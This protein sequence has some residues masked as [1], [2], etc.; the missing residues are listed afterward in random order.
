MSVVFHDLAGGLEVSSTRAQRLAL[1]G[2]TVTPAPVSSVTMQ[3]TDSFTNRSRVHATDRPLV[4]VHVPHWQH[5]GL[6][7]DLLSLPLLTLDPSCAL[8]WTSFGLLQQSAACCTRFPFDNHLKL[9]K[10]P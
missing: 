3:L 2:N 7:L 1:G 6:D 8:G 5:D 4:R 10:R 9:G